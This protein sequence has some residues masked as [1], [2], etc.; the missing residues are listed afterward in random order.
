M[1]TKIRQQ[2][3][4]LITALFIMALIAAAAAAMIIQQRISIA[5]TQQI[6]NYD[7][8][9]QYGQVVTDW[10][11]Y[12]LQQDLLKTSK[13]QDVFPKIYPHSK[14]PRGFFMGQVFD[15][16]GKF[17]LNNLTKQQYRIPFTHMLSLIFPK[18]KDQK[19]ITEAI[20]NWVSPQGTFDIADDQ[21]Y[22]KAGLP[23]KVPHAF[24]QNITQLRQVLGISAQIY[25]KLL[26]YVTALPTITKIN[27]NTAS[28]AVLTTL[29]SKL[30]LKTAQSIIK[31]RPL[32]R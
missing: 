20:S 13:P 32:C 4:A 30:N 1:P 5:R 22:K 18:R 23:Y 2:G 7:Q 19:D 9:V 8:A 24:M 17:N 12:N 3:A 16:Q 29:S 11:L 28:D 10:A 14:V 27:D 21:A 15:L 6:I 26:P 25:L 31:S